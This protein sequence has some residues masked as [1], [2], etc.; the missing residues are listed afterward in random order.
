MRRPE[1]SPASTTWPPV[2]P[3]TR[4]FSHRPPHLELLLTPGPGLASLGLSQE[5]RRWWDTTRSAVSSNHT[6]ILV[7]S[8]LTNTISSARNGGYWIG[9]YPP[10]PSIHQLYNIRA[11]L[12]AM[13][14]ESKEYR[15]VLVGYQGSYNLIYS[16]YLVFHVRCHST[17]INTS[18]AS[19]SSHPPNTNTLTSATEC[20]QDLLSYILI[21]PIGHG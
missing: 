12:S 14:S 10:A 1:H 4:R 16:W 20:R 19:L 7:T 3:H 2:R 15:I 18:D 6:N 13:L 8:G 17:L 11:Y 9:Y 21:Q 5:R